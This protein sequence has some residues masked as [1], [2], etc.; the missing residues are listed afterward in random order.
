MQSSSDVTQLL[1]SLRAGDRSALDRLPPLAY[2]ELRRLA[3]SI[4]RRQRSDHTMQPT[5][6]V[7][8][9]YLRLV[10]T[11]RAAVADSCA[12]PGGCGAR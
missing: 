2:E 12:L 1:V 7:H 4:F 6:P 11:G 5:A 9:A 8:E 10:D 3:Q